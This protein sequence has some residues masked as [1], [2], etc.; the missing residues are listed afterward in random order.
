MGIG[1]CCCAGGQNFGTSLG[2]EYGRSSASVNEYFNLGLLAARMKDIAV[3]PDNNFP[4][5]VYDIQVLYNT[6]EEG[7]ENNKLY[8]ASGDHGVVE[9]SVGQYIQNQTNIYFEGENDTTTF[10]GLLG[11]IWRGDELGSRYGYENFSGAYGLEIYKNK[12]VLVAHGTNGLSVI[13][14]ETGESFNGIFKEENTIF[15]QIQISGGNVFLGTS[16]YD[17]PLLE[18]YYEEDQEWYQPEFDFENPNSYLTNFNSSYGGQNLTN[19]GVYVF[20]VQ[21]LLKSNGIIELEEGEEIEQSFLFNCPTSYSVNR[22]KSAG[23]GSVYVATGQ[24]EENTYGGY[25]TD[26]NQDE[27]GELLKINVNSEIEEGYEKETIDSGSAFID[28]DVHAG[29]LYYLVSTYSAPFVKK[30]STEE[31]ISNFIDI[32]S[33][34]SKTFCTDPFEF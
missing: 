22:I 13:N 7:V 23:S 20:N 4:N 6:N 8:V 19:N 11:Q 14:S 5:F 9:Y 15:N 12:Y 29:N 10:D 17:Y 30:Y 18:Y 32:K 2:Y 25:P 27:D 1:Y 16:G 21:N 26:K 31:G 34:T 33:E 24:R 3:I 28:M